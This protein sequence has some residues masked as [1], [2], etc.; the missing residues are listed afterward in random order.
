MYPQAPQTFPAF[1]E[2]PSGSLT[3]SYYPT[4]LT[5][6]YPTCT[7]RST[8]TPTRSPRDWI[9]YWTERMDRE[10]SLR[11]YS[12]ATRR[13]YLPALKDFLSSHPCAPSK[14]G[15]EAIGR[16]LLKCKEEK[17][18][19]AST[20]NL[21]LAALLFFYQHVIKAPHC[22]A[23]IPRMKEDKKL[24]PVMAVGKVKT[25]IDGLSNEKHR[26]MLSLAYGCGFGVSELRGLKL[27]DLDFER[28]II[29]IL[30]GKGRKD[31]RVMLPG[32]LMEEIS[33]YRKHYT[34]LTYLFESHLA[35]K[36]L[37]KRT[38]QAVFGN[39]CAKSGMGGKGGIHS[40]HHS[41][42]THVLEAGMDLRFIQALLGHSSSKETERH[43]HV[44]V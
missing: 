5:N 23:G 32:S 39:A 27:N 19:G 43:T 12:P 36:A 16:Y 25:L 40:R 30:N 31:R 14:M 26:L 18:L 21:I 11:N 10:L 34:P 8:P 28:G 29:R 3:P 37:S 6:P 42:A 9:G 35:G 4:S 17:G 15:P 38:F 24:P 20:I 33:R 44:T 41:F 1:K 2:S 7:E 22:V 13:N